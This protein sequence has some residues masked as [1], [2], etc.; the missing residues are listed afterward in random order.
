MLRWFFTIFI[1]VIMLSAALPWLKK[2]GL[3][4]LPGDL[5]FRLFGR[6][7]SLPFASTILLSLGALLL[8]KLL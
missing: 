7:F 1:A 4:C 6:Q 5:N 3:G 8:G 2:L